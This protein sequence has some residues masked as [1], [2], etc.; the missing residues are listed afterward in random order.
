MD[1]FETMSGDSLYH[2][3]TLNTSMVGLSSEFITP[4]SFDSLELLNLDSA[5]NLG[6]NRRPVSEPRR[7]GAYTWDSLQ[8]QRRK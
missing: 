1:Q 3:A 8:V 6:S 4:L 2:S 5:L 7:K